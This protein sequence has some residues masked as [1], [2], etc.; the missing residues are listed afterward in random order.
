MGCVGPPHPSLAPRAPTHQTAVV[1][2]FEPGGGEMQG[3]VRGA[4]SHLS[5]QVVGVRTVGG[6]GEAPAAVTTEAHCCVSLCETSP[7]TVPPLPHRDR[8]QGAGAR[9]MSPLPWDLHRLRLWGGRESEGEK[10]PEE[11][12]WAPAGGWG[13]GRGPPIIKLVQWVHLGP[14]E[15]DGET[16]RQRWE[17]TEETRPRGREARREGRKCGERCS[18]S[19]R[20]GESGWRSDG[21]TEGERRLED[22]EN[23]KRDRGSKRQRAETTKPKESG[24]EADT[25]SEREMERD[26]AGD[27]E[28]ETKLEGPRGEASAGGRETSVPGKIFGV[29]G[30]QRWDGR[31]NTK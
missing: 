29:Q 24:Q 13:R 9:Q 7:T 11:E 15:R 10:V 19:P 1:W 5:L 30:R 28:T 2:P 3:H 12:V 27:G 6:W 16:P 14:E 17:N 26:P 25:G 18:C 20:E 8:K 31:K 23:R 22:R 21:E 4:F